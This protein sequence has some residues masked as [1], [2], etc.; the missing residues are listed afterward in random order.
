MLKKSAAGAGRYRVQR[1]LS[2]AATLPTALAACRQWDRLGHRAEVLGGDGE[3]GRAARS[4]S[5]T[6]VARSAQ[7]AKRSHLALVASMNPENEG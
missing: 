5:L 6:V 7:A 1:R 3:Q 2:G 4:E